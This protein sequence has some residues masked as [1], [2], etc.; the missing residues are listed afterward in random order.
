MDPQSIQKQIDALTKRL[1]A[2]N[3]SATFPRNV[4]TAIL[5]RLN[6]PTIIIGTAAPVSTPLKIGNIFCDRTNAKVYISTG[7]SSST[8]WKI[9]N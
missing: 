9:L 7:L 3:Y 6:T 2:L 4:E 1:D 5:E 8:D